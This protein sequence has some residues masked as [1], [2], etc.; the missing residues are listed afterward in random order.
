MQSFSDWLQQLGAKIPSGIGDPYKS[1]L[2]S[3]TRY[4]KAMTGQAQSRISQQVTDLISAGLY[5][6]NG[7]SPLGRDFVTQ[8][9]RFGANNSENV[10]VLIL[11]N[12]AQRHASKRYYDVVA[13][14]AKMASKV[15]GF[16]VLRNHID[17]SLLLTRL[18]AVKNDYC[19]LND[20]LDDLDNQSFINELTIPNLELR[21]TNPALLDSF[22]R[23][24][25]EW[26]Q[27]INLKELLNAV[28]IVLATNKNQ[29]IDSRLFGNENTLA[30]TIIHYYMSHNRLNT[31][32]YG[33]P[34][35]GKTYN[36]VLWAL[37]KVK[38]ISLSQAKQ[39][40]D[41]KAEFDSLVSSGNIVFVTFHQS[42]SYEDFVEGIR[43]VIKKQKQQQGG[44][45][46]GQI[47]YEVIPG[48][49]KVLCERAYASSNSAQPENFVLIIDEI[50]RGN[51]SNIFG[52]LI[53][54]I[55]PSKRIGERDEARVC[56]TY[57]TDP[58]RIASFGVPA[59]LFI[60]GTMN[61]AD[62]SIAF[63]DS[64]LRR[65]FD[66]VEY[67]PDDNLLGEVAI[68]GTQ[69]SLKKLLT[70]INE[71]IEILLDKDHTIGHSYLLSANNK[72]SLASALI[73]KIIPLIQEYFYNDY[74]KLR[75]VFGDL[76][77]NKP[78]ADRIFVKRDLSQM[79]GI[80]SLI[81][82]Y[83]DKEFYEL[84]PL[85]RVEDLDTIPVSIIT[86]IYQY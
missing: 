43:P 62:K 42:Y 13:F 33:P 25:N 45:N 61:S 54:L 85:L 63:I 34:G 30:K 26:S 64:A 24:V 7:P 41:P 55:E 32:L 86:S 70:T 39:L 51:I 46:T 8:V 56:L 6:G 84:N 83:G 20:F 17:K 10:I 77:Q 37:S 60:I 28:E 11:L 79:N 22:K 52:E 67:M 40:P 14:W 68:D 1:S 66:F 59:N 36:T 76:N 47:E 50:N 49:F 35:T 44:N 78:V 9:T 58:N 23:N 38:G 2:R 18:S 27:R 3:A 82:G 12:E 21:V 81:E 57:S 53:T 72:K 74:K 15:G 4:Y 29:T 19:P 69:V 31:I 80:D 16:N 65:R 71:R 48:V 73:N 5:E 75:F